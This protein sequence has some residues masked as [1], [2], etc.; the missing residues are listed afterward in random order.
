MSKEEAMG[1][2]ENLGEKAEA[3]KEK[4]S[5]ENRLSSVDNL[6]MIERISRNINW[7]EGVE[8]MI[9]ENILI[10]NLEGAV[11]CCLKCGRSVIPYNLL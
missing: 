3:A 11:E 10:G 7:N 2:F 6:G 4:P 8:K 9:K 5:R 1:F